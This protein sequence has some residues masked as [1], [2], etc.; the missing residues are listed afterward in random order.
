M[1]SYDSVVMTSP[2]IKPGQP[3]YYQ[4]I[5]YNDVQISDSGEYLHQ[6]AAVSRR[7]GVKNCS[8]GRVRMTVDGE[9]G[10]GAPPTR[11]TRWPSPQAAPSR[12]GQRRGDWQESWPTWLKGSPPGR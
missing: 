3:G 5:V 8:D 7:L 4:E 10:G 11:G 6:A 1:G 9:P 12:L 2:D